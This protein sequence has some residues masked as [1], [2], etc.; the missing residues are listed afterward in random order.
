MQSY[1]CAGDFSVLGK[2][3]RAVIE[4]AVYYGSYL[5]IFVALLIYVAASPQLS[6]DM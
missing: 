4:N 3:K 5:L 2:I 1:S 6:L